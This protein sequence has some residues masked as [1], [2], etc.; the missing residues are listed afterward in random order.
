[1]IAKI[2]RTLV[3]HYKTMNIFNGIQKILVKYYILFSYTLSEIWTI[4]SKIE[5]KHLQNNLR[6]NNFILL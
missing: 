5:I 2:E 4:V 1:M 3:L 6:P